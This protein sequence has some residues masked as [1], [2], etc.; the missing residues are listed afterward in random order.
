MKT[1]KELKWRNY[2][3]LEDRI[4][5]KLSLSEIARRNKITTERVRQIFFKLRRILRHVY[6]GE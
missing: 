3:M 2:N 5:H 6:L 4:Q 1:T